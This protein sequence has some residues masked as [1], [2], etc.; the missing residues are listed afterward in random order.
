MDG[1]MGCGAMAFWWLLVIAVLV[2]GVWVLVRAINDRG[3]P[4]TRGSRT[5][6]QILEERFARGDIERE[7]FEERRRALED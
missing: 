5:A 6:L 3:Q 2:G 1:M 4:P 7:E